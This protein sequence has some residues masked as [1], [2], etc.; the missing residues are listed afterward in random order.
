ME[1]LIHGA[2]VLYLMSYVMRDILWLRMF[3]VVGATCLI[4]YLYLRPDPLFTAIYWNLLFVGLNVIWI[5]RL[6]LERRPVKLNEDE[7]RL[8]ELVFR[9]IDPRDMVKLLKLGTWES[10]EKDECFLSQGS[11]LDR[12][13]VIHAGKACLQVDGKLVAELHPGQFIGGIRF[14]T[15]ETAPANVVALEPTRYV[16]WPKSKLKDYLAKNPALHAA[17]QI[18]LGKD[19]TSRLRDSWDRQDGDRTFS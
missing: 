8:C 4:S 7:Q 18:T 14:I 5:I 6:I 10:A 15:D 3:T 13:M 19:V 17:I 12:L 16:A 9:T 11:E 2:N 1:Y